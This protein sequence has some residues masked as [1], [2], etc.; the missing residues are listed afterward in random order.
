LISK[1]FSVLVLAHKGET[2]NFFMLNVQPPE[3][4]TLENI[5]DREYI[6][7]V[8]VSGSM[9][10]FPLNTTKELFKNLAKTLRETD[11]FNI[12]FFAGGGNWLADYSLPATDDNIEKAL[13]SQCLL[14]RYRLK[15]E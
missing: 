14:F 1:D 3:R 2:D 7:I 4:V 8:D 11:K 6:F 10:G 13:K 15:C 12:L 5:P 9:N